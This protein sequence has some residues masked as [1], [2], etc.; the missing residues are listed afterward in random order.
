[1][2]H[3]TDAGTCE[4]Q[5]LAQGNVAAVERCSCG[6]IKLVMGPM[7]LRF[8]ADALVDLQQTLSAALAEL[9]GRTSAVPT[10]VF[11]SMP[12]GQA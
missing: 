8:D 9:R 5:R 2:K 1:M 3:D 11:A 10:P 12:R 7:T 6:V 4:R